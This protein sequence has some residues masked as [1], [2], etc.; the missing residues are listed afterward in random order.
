MGIGDQRRGSNLLLDCFAHF[1][2]ETPFPDCGARTL[3]AASRLISTLA[4]TGNDIAETAHWRLGRILRKAIIAP[5]KKHPANAQENITSILSVP[6][7]CI[8]KGKTR[9]FGR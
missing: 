1:V 6:S 3:R 9:K 4:P 7:P 2:T 5:Y 8:D